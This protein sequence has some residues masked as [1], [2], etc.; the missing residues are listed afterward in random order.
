VG[1]LT[2][3]DA[4]PHFGLGPRQKV[5]RLEIRWPSGQVQVLTNIASD[6]ILKVREP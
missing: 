5:D 3:G 1:F 6:Q 2:Q 4:R